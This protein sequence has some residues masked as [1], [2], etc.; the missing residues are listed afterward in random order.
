MD[1]RPS[2]LLVDDEEL[3][4]SSV[5]RLLRREFDV[6]TAMSVEDAIARTS[7]MKFDAVVT[8]HWL[9]AG[10]N[11]LDL[12]GH[13]RE[14]CPQTLRVLVT[15]TSDE[16]FAEDRESGLIQVFL[17]KPFVAQDLIAVLQTR[18]G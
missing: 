15:G 12:L 8:D 16:K 7:V 10:G 17:E 1:Q 13:V 6:V 5:S 11:G 18:A 14:H 3:V 9:G 2:V 4:L